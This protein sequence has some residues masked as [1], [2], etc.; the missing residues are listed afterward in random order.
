[1]ARVTISAGAAERALSCDAGRGAALTQIAVDL[2]ARHLVASE[3]QELEGLSLNPSPAVRPG[4][5]V[6]EDGEEAAVGQLLDLHD[7][8]LR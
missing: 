8:E 4:S 2:G 3:A 1:M 6:F 7:L 5:R